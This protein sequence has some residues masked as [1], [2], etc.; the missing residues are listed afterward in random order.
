VPR[1]FWWSRGSWS[2]TEATPDHIRI[3]PHRR[4]AHRSRRPTWILDLDQTDA[5]Q[6]TSSC[7][8]EEQEARTGSDN[9]DDDQ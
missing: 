2:R 7:P 5:P 6:E 9:A 4:N 8:G 3:Q 1:Q